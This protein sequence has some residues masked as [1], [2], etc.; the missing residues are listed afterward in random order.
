MAYEQS[1]HASRSS[2]GDP[3]F[4]M[5]FPHN[6]QGQ[7]SPVS[8]QS[9]WQPSGFSMGM[10]MASSSQPVFPGLSRIQ[11]HNMSPPTSE[12]QSAFYPHNTVTNM[13]ISL[14]TSALNQPSQQLPSILKGAW[15]VVGQQTSQSVA[16]GSRSFTCMGHDSQP[17]NRESLERTA[18]CSKQPENMSRGTA[19]G[20]GNSADTSSPLNMFKSLYSMSLMESKTGPGSGPL[21]SGVSGAGDSH[22]KTNR[23]P[24][25]EKRKSL[26]V[27]SNKR[28]SLD[29]R[30]VSQ[31]LQQVASS[32]NEKGKKPDVEVLEIPDATSSVSKASTKIYS[33][34]K[35]VVKLHRL[36]NQLELKGCTIAQST[37]TLSSEVGD[38]ACESGDRGSD[39]DQFGANDLMDY[40]ELESD[41]DDIGS[42][43]DNDADAA[44]TDNGKKKVGKKKG[45]GKGKGSS[46]KGRP[47][48]GHQQ[49]GKVK[50]RRIGKSL[51]FKI[52]NRSLS[53][54]RKAA[55]K[56]DTA[57]ATPKLRRL[58]N[59]DHEVVLKDGVV[60]YRCKLCDKDYATSSLLRYHDATHS[61]VKV[62]CTECDSLFA[63]MTTMK[64][65]IK[66]V[67]QKHKPYICSQCGAGYSSRY[68]LNEHM[69]FHTGEKRHTCVTC[70]KSFAH[71]S[72]L[73]KHMMQHT[74]ERPH[75]CEECNMGFIQV[76]TLR[77]HM[78]KAHN[79]EKPFKCDQCDAG[80]SRKFMLDEHMYS[81]TGTR[82]FQCMVCS[83]NF[84]SPLGL[85]THMRIHIDKDR[86]KCTMCDA[87]FHRK[88]HLE[89]HMMRH[90]GERPHICAYCGKRFTAKSILDRHTLTHTGERPY[91]CQVCGR[92]FAGKSELNKH[93][94][95]HSGERPFICQTC[96]KSFAR[97]SHL[98]QHLISHL[99]EKNYACP[100][101][102]STFTHPRYLK[103]HI[104]THDGLKPFKCSFC[105]ATFAS[106]VNLQKHMVHHVGPAMVREGSD[107]HIQIINQ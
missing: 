102:N 74:G 13:P 5:G 11:S 30:R 51:I 39:P 40:P 90:T 16:S 105:T 73:K 48:L 37:S 6:L 60:R 9:S 44:K 42:W 70:G 93:S 33:P 12:L 106:K 29:P 98:S 27:K 96:G 89:R 26:V 36:E 88:A 55:D 85:K 17:G 81:H 66:L 32:E 47:K 52:K 18:T 95:I 8:M 72:T 45:R 97:K 28:K 34:P 2:P 78:I 24:L 38:T 68:N 23:I 71:R 94:T 7:Q 4:Q 80:F 15:N 86:Y 107:L 91:K 104:K 58:K 31:G 62:K 83:A 43:G 53:T 35:C 3:N 77:E 63:R 57:P 19:V 101:C 25:M 103:A 100:I 54:V 46:R 1:P 64:Q 82:P 21:L 61:G 41:N 79:A 56:D 67:H 59:P 14:P 10:G 20:L 65:H 50:Q 76:C 87:A 99:T 69:V 22:G 75:R 84:M 92:D 49:K